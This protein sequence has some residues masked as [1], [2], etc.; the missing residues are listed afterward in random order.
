MYNNL[1]FFKGLDYDLNITLD[2]QGIWKST[3]Y[4]PEVSVGL[5]ESMNIF[6]LEE[7]I[8]NGDVI[9]NFPTAETNN[10]T[11]FIFEWNEEDPSD[12]KD[13]I[14]YTIDNSGNI[15]TIKQLTS[16]T[17]NLF[18]YSN[19][20]S[21]VN[22]TKYLNTQSN[23]A[24]QLN[25][26]LNSTK[27]GP[28]RRTL[29]IYSSVGGV[30]TLIGILSIYGEVVAE[31]ER[32]AVLL[33]NFGASLGEADFM[34]FKDHDIS[35]M[36]PDYILLNQKR[37]EL[38]LEL[39]NIKPFVGTYKAILNAIDFFGYDK[40]T[41]KEYWLNIDSATKNF[42]KM[43]GVPVPHSSV[44]GEAVRKKL[45]FK[46]PSNTM[47]KTS[48]F[49]LVYRLNEPNGT[50]DEWD[51]PNVTETF[52]YTPE[53]VLIKLYGLKAK[54]QKEYLPLQA[55]IIDITAEGDYFDQRNLN[56][57]HNQNP[58][59]F[60]SEGHDIKFKVLPEDRDL[61]IEDMSMVL[62]STMDQNDDSSNYNLF[63]NLG[64]GNE[65]NLTTANVVKITATRG[66]SF[67][68]QY[69]STLANS[70][71]AYNKM[72]NGT[73]VAGSPA[74]FVEG[75]ITLVNG[76]IYITC[77]T[78]GIQPEGKLLT[79]G[80]VIP[81]NY[82]LAENNID[83]VKIYSIEEEFNNGYANRS[84]LKNVISKFYETYHDRELHSYNPNVPI[85]C[86]IILDGTDSFDDIWDEAKFTWEDAQD[87]NSTLLITWD[88]WWKSWVYE[89]EWVVT[90]KETGFNQTYRG[91]IDD[92]L[93][94]PLV[95]PYADSYSI[96]M[97]TYDLF[98]HRSHYRLNDLFE[99]KL[100]QLELYGIYKWLEDQSWDNKKLA[101]NKSGGYWN[102]PQD[103]Q[104]SIDDNIATLY[105]TLDRANYVH[106]EEDQGVRF[107]TVRRYLDIYSESGFSETTGP[108][109]WDESAFRWKDSEHLAWNYTRV[110]ADLTSS[111]KINYIENG[112]TLVI[113]YIDPKTGQV[114]VGTHII[115]SASATGVTDITGWTAIMNELNSNMDPI[116]NKFNYN[117]I[118][119]DLNDNNI[120]DV[121]RF[122]LAVGNEYSNT[123]DFS[124]V[125]II[126]AN[127]LSNSEVTGETH[128]THYNPTWDDTRVFRDFAEVERST[129][130]TIST[131]ISKFPGRKNAKW[132]ITNISNPE[133]ND[134]YYNN[135]W[136]TYIFK[137]PGYYS[138]E[139][140]A[141]D[142]YGNK[143]VVKRNMLKVK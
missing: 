111:F 52:D 64:I 122:M 62:K 71:I 91:A 72:P 29:N 21:I 67:S 47:K 137:E 89:I 54:L 115:T 141:E 102:S 37:K 13:I 45:S 139:L 59:G 143:N 50:Y 81:G 44:R 127:P 39:H 14:L 76:V 31:D 43:F 84:E 56:I 132:T 65:D 142:T 133:I 49:S 68:P 8:F 78:D 57:W 33:S 94:I 119:E 66:K 128:V 138:I 22:E 20:D 113:E 34:L 32:L 93:I 16:Q 61:F 35:E 117:A 131:D 83:Y 124:N 73:F 7:C 103:S 86:P 99:I 46:L 92:Y 19:V 135:M 9:V 79:S 11:T 134:I 108:Y 106:F 30:K 74:T 90:S 26:A 123:Y 97:R 110:G 4:L 116:I 27:E 136:L 48:K 105:L 3:V 28:H 87:P 40:L 58:I 98:G 25:V 75:R 112:D 100:K 80:S 114:M 95:L 24:I 85:G 96:E 140:E 51:I 23:V 120:N 5:Y 36:S 17:E 130:V 12:S 129:H 10:A 118:F 2:S 41:L 88:N 77:P 82:L 15:P 1:R 70:L 6:I 42:G 107:S 55:K 121:F 53:E 18:D 104:I 109:Q 101:W 60:F 126:K 38:L 63:L 125:S 69:A